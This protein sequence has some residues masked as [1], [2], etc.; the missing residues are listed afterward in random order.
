MGI[1]LSYRIVQN[2]GEYKIDL[3]FLVVCISEKIKL[4]RI[5]TL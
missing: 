5:V 4:A 3:P 1:Q 2:K